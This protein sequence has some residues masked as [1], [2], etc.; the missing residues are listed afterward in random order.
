[1]SMKIASFVV[2]AAL[3][4]M[5]GFG[6][7]SGANASTTRAAASCC[8]GSACDCDDCSCDADNACCGTDACSCDAC[9]CGDAAE[10][11]AVPGKPETTA[12][13]AN[14]ATDCCAK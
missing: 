9:K 7:M 13:K 6:A 8:C 5:A 10:A 3:A 2:F 14:C 12:P 4:L 11:A 1:M